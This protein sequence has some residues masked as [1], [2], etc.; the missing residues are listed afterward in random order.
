MVFTKVLLPKISRKCRLHML[1]LNFFMQMEQD[2]DLQLL[3][4]HKRDR[5]ST[6]KVS[7]ASD[8]TRGS[9]GED[10]SSLWKTSNAHAVIHNGALIQFQQ[11]K[12][13]PGGDPS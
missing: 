3:T 12:I 11:G 6:V 8:V 7:P 1:K 10:L 2:N 5:G 4:W 13:I 9:M